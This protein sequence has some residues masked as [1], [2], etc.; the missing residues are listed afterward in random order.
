[1]YT[2]KFIY[3]RA[4]VAFAVILVQLYTNT[5]ITLIHILYIYVTFV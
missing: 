3:T 1:M 2:G 5:F 4:C